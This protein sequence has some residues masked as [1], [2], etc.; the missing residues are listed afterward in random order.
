MNELSAT[1][2][3]HSI[4][5]SHIFDAKKATLLGVIIVIFLFF[6]ISAPNFLTAQNLMFVILKVSTIIIVATAATLLMVTGKPKVW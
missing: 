1:D 5:L 3:N 2:S 6:T 4:Q